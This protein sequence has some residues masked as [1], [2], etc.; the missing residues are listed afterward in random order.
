MFQVNILMTGKVPLLVL[1]KGSPTHP[2]NF[3]DLHSIVGNDMRFA[4]VAW[5]IIVNCE[6]NDGVE[7]G[8]L[9]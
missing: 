9:E 1:L 2:V 7:I 6:Q 5:Q 3:V 4:D 8:N